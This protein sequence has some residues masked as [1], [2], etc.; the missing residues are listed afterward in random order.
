MHLSKFFLVL[1]VAT[2]VFGSAPPPCYRGASCNTEPTTSLPFFTFRVYC[3]DIKHSSF[4][5][6]SGTK[7]GVPGE[8]NSFSFGEAGEGSV[9]PGVHLTFRSGAGKVEVNDVDGKLIGTLEYRSL[10]LPLVCK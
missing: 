1:T 5:V 4:L 9:N 7:V 3:P 10:S 8:E 2:Q 6:A